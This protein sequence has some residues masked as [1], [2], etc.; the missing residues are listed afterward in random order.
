MQTSGL[1]WCFFFAMIA[2]LAAA[3]TQPTATLAVVPN[4]LSGDVSIISSTTNSEVTRIPVGPSPMLATASSD[5]QFA[6]IASARQTYAGHATIW[7]I[8]FASG[9]VVGSITLQLGEE[10]F[11]LTVSPD[12][13]RLAA[14][15]Q[16]RARLFMLDTAS[17]TVRWSSQLCALCDGLTYALNAPARLSFSPTSQT[18]TALVPATSEAVTLVTDTGLLLSATSSGAPVG[19]GVPFTDVA[20]FA[21]LPQ[22]MLSAHPMYGVQLYDTAAGYTVPL[23]FF[24]GDYPFDIELGVFANLIVGFAGSI[25]YDPNPDSLKI[26]SFNHWAGITLPS[27]ESLRWLRYNPVTQEIWGTCT[28]WFGGAGTCSPATIDSFAL[29]NGGTRTTTALPSG[30]AVGGLP[31]FSPDFQ[32]YYQ[33]LPN[34]QIVV[35]DAASKVQLLTIQ[36]GNAP[37]MVVFQG[38]SSEKEPTT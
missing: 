16:R 2:Q 26:F 5:G 4:L 18:I 8:D 6:Y 31:S 28:T 23:P 38:D 25:E 10:F 19:E 20:R 32:Y 29:A 37:Q 22:F 21:P 34:N 17:M 7:K 30:L 36:V 27:S 15:D 9:T 14:V 12:G 24:A 11:A 35:I 3:Q 33:P 13:T 1:R